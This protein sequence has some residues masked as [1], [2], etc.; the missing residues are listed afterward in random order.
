MGISRLFAKE[1]E[2][3]RQML[4]LQAFKPKFSIN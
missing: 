2:N 4:E 3:L 1:W